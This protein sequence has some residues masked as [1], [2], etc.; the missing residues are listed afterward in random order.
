MQELPSGFP[1][2]KLPVVLS[3]EREGLKEQ[4]HQIIIISIAQQLVQTIYKYKSYAAHSDFE[5]SRWS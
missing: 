1:F 4:T 5:N 2:R 3:D